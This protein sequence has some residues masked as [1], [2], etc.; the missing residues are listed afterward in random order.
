MTRLSLLVSSALLLI[1]GLARA[2][3]A[4]DVDKY[5][6]CDGL[7][8]DAPCDVNIPEFYSGTC[9]NIPCESDP[10]MTCLVCIEPDVGGTAGGT[11]G[12]VTTGGESTAGGTAGEAGSPTT[13]SAS[14]GGSGSSG[15]AGSSSGSGSTGDSSPAD[16]GGCSC[17]SRDRAPMGGLALLL[18]AALLR[19]RRR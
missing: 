16:K 8:P 19:R 3:V 6:A 18:G 9:Q 13:G 14:S 2:D 17:N 15:A 1:P 7:T 5:M 4:P 11:A 10:Q 12:P